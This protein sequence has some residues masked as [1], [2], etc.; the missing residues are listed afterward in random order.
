MTD[1]TALMIILGAVGLAFGLAL[2]VIQ[3]GFF[4]S[5]KVQFLHD[6]VYVPS[7]DAA[8]VDMIALANPQP[9]EIVADLGS[10]NGKLLI[11]FSELAKQ[12][13][14]FEVGPFLVWESRHK[15]QKLG[16]VTKVQIKWQ[17]FWS[18]DVSQTDVIL[19]FMTA[20]IMAK[21]EKKLRAELKPGARVISQRFVFP[22]WPAAKKLGESTLYIQE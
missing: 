19:L 13:I 10:G 3:I 6:P 21:L 9:H 7:K 14:G 22:N 20:S 5:T 8:V 1:L 12:A 17:S 15:I 4:V 18:A 2:V 16:L 11:A